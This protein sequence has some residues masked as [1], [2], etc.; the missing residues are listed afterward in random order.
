MFAHLDAFDPDVESVAELKEHY[1]R[2][3]LGDATVKKRLVGILDATLRPIRERRALFG[4]DRTYV[5]DI[6]GAGT[7]R[8][9]A[10]TD[11]VANDVRRAFALDPLPPAAHALR[12]SHRGLP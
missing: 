8:A 5:L 10:V 9:R 12:A 11:R 7:A 1:R 3:G 4:N 2:G 6:I